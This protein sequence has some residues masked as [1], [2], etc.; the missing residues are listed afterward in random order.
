[1]NVGLYS[2]NERSADDVDVGEA[3]GEVM[4]SCKKD[5]SK[6]VGVSISSSHVGE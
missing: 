1:V 6:G 5:G 3:A 2:S 4:M